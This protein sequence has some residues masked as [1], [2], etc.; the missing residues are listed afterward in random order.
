[1]FWAQSS[2]AEIPIREIVAA[3]SHLTWP[4]TSV[5]TLVQRLRGCRC[6]TSPKTI[7][8]SMH[9]PQTRRC[10]KTTLVMQISLQNGTK[11]FRHGTASKSAT[12][13]SSQVP[14]A[15]YLMQE[16][17]PSPWT[18]ATAE[19]QALKQRRVLQRSTHQT[20]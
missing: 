2:A 7:L 20:C 6:V 12:S 13:S 15:M 17:V 5:Q 11:S 19:H 10:S 16:M 3:L 9:S 14:S 4:L 1:M 18:C 8:W